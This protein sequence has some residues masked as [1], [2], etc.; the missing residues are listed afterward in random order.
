MLAG[1]FLG[2]PLYFRSLMAGAM[3]IIIWG[4]IVYISFGRGQQIMRRIAF[5]LSSVVLM[6]LF[7]VSV[8]LAGVRMNR[9][10]IPIAAERIVL[11]GIQVGNTIED[12]RSLFGEPTAEES[13]YS[14]KDE[15]N[16]I[17]WSYDDVMSFRFLESDDGVYRLIVMTVKANN[18]VETIDGV[19]VGMSDNVLIKT[20]GEP[21]LIYIT[22]TGNGTRKNYCYVS[23][24]GN[25]LVFFTQNGIIESIGMGFLE[26]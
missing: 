12:V 15:A 18:G 6:M 16:Y 24:G 7:C 2:I 21:R 1:G 10:A 3:V 19:T 20:Y 8:C 26:G 14:N 23:S 22:K 4:W 9:N 11:G 25:K 17:R 5:I 13:G